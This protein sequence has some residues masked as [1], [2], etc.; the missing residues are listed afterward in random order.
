MKS[1]S[2]SNCRVPFSTHSAVMIYLSADDSSSL[3]ALDALGVVMPRVDCPF[4]TARP[5]SQW[6]ILGS[7]I[8][9]GHNNTAACPFHSTTRLDGVY[10]FVLDCIVHWP[11]H[12][13][14]SDPIVFGRP[15]RATTTA[16]DYRQSSAV[17][18]PQVSFAICICARV[19]ARHVYSVDQN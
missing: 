18:F 6:C 11:R 13:A 19:I 3:V 2:T 1:N 5:V 9:A 14:L 17:E 15:N 16:A 12:D 4:T 8:R 10:L 7:A